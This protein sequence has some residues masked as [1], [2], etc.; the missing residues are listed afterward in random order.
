VFP[1]GLSEERR[2][3]LAAVSLRD[4]APEPTVAFV[5]TF[6]Y[7]KG[8]GE[9]GEVF[10]RLRSAIPKARL[11]LIGTRGV[12]RT[13]SDVLSFFHRRDRASV[14][15]VEEFEPA[16]LPEL[17][18]GAWV[19]TFPSHYEGFPFGVLEMLAA[20]LP[21]VAYDAP[22]LSMMLRDEQLVKPGDARQM[23]A[24]LGLLLVDRTRLARE[25]A[26]ARERAGDFQWNQIAHETLVC[27]R[28]LLKNRAARRYAPEEVQVAAG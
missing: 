28:E 27:Y 2:A 21:V 16:K 24:K 18:R 17:L 10:A 1:Y 3:A 8:A 22:G 4:L 15:V 9:F 23:A 19:G 13:K 25:R 7:R 11:R 6:E 20:G 12:C 5:G 14:D 26:W